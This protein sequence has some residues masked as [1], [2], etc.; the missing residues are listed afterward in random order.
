MKIA[1]IP[2]SALLIEKCMNV[3]SHLKPQGN[4]MGKLSAAGSLF[5]IIFLASFGGCFSRLPSSTVY[6]P[7]YVTRTFTSTNAPVVTTTRPS[8]RTT[9]APVIIKTTQIVISYGPQ[10]TVTADPITRTVAE[11]ITENVQP[12]TRTVIPPPTTMYVIK[13]G[14]IILDIGA[15]NTDYFISAFRGKTLNFSFTITGV[16]VY[17]RVIDSSGKLVLIGNAGDGLTSEGAIVMALSEFYDFQFSSSS[18]TL[19]SVV[20]LYYWY[21]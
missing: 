13:T 5:I 18:S 10:M 14:P 8:A 1:D 12:T 7:T 17:L 9:L 15:G 4:L 2:V 6:V 20:L 3:N 19:P 21:S 16:R 11:Y